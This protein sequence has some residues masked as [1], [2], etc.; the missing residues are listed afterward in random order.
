MATVKEIIES[1]YTKV[2]GEK[3][4]LLP[5][6]SDFNTYLEVLNICMDNWFH[7]PYV[8][9]QSL[10][11]MEYVLPEVVEE[12]KLVYNLPNVSEVIIANSPYDGI[13]FIKD[14]EVKDKYTLLKPAMFENTNKLKSATA[15]DK[16]YLKFVGEDIIGC[17][18]RVPVYKKPEKYTNST[19]EVKIDSIAWLISA[20]SAFICDSSPVPFIARNADKYAKEAQMYM[21]DMRDNN[22]RLQHLMITTTSKDKRFGSLSAAID[23]GFGVGGVIGGGEDWTNLDGGEF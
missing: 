19:Q 17:A 7:T 16:L 5:A 8:K 14:D 22:R 15:T 23:A 13:Y 4:T 12:H 20:M 21:K 18:I 1:T 10:Y 2:N 11:D 6:S 3:E 9:W